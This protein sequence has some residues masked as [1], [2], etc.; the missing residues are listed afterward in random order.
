[1]WWGGGRGIHV[2]SL[3][4]WTGIEWYELKGIAVSAGESLAGMAN[5]LWRVR[6]GKRG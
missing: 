4:H 2:Q 6:G 3:K 1:M 5:G